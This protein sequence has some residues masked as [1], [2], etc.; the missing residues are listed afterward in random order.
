MRVELDELYSETITV[1]NRLGARES[2]A[3]ADTYRATVL[4]GCVWSEKLTRSVDADGS[5][6]IVKSY[7]VQV[8]EASAAN[9][10]DPLHWIARPEGSYTVRGGDFI[11]RGEHP[12]EPNPSN[13]R[14]YLNDVPDAFQVKAF[15]DLRGRYGL[16][17]VPS[18]A[19]RFAQALQVEG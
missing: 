17:Y 18:G 11:A 19:L 14:A 3:K 1:F 13:L 9:Y 5:V 8:P 12:D 7:I 2:G 15:R 6:H 4:T 16:D 10:L